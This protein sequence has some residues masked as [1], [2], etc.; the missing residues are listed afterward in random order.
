MLLAFLIFK[1]LQANRSSLDVLD[2]G[3]R[4]WKYF[5]LISVLNRGYLEFNRGVNVGRF[6]NYRPVKGLGVRRYVDKVFERSRAGVAFQREDFFGLAMLET[7]VRDVA[8]SRPVQV[9][10]QK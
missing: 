10:G 3:S 5:F 6:K 2:R 4:K 1:F 7:E 9:S 8:G